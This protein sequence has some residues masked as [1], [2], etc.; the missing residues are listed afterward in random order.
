MCARISPKETAKDWKL[1]QALIAVN[2]FQP[3]VCYLSDCLVPRLGILTIMCPRP[4][5]YLLVVKE[6]TAK[7]LKENRVRTFIVKCK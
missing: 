6:L 4:Q 3:D 2:L 5:L 7:S 1:Q